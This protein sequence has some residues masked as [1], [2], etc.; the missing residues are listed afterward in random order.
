MTNDDKHKQLA[1]D[2]LKKYDKESNALEHKGLM[3]KFVSALAIAFSV[4]QLYT[5]IFGV[6][7]AQLQRAVHLGFG[8]ALVYLLYPTRRA[9]LEDGV[10]PIDLVLAFLGAAAPAYLIIEYNELVLRAGTVTE[11]DF[12][13]GLLGVLL[14]IEATRRIVGLPMVCVVLIFLGYAFLGPE[15]PGV[16][17][18]RGLTPQQLVGHLFFT[19]EGIFG[20]PLGVSSTFIFLF[21]LF[22]AYL[23]STGLGKFFI[24]LANALAGWAS[25]GPAKVAV[26][27]S[28]LMGTVS[29]SS[30]A[31]VAGTGSF[32]IPMMKKLG[33][34]KEFAGAVE[35]AASTGGQLMPPVMG[36]AAF[37]MAE[38]VG[39]PYIEIVKA[40]IIPAILYFTGVWLGVHFEAKRKGLKGIPKEELPRA[41]DIFRE[42]GHLALPLV[43][44]IY[45]LVS[46]YTP[47]RAAL[48][49]IVLSILASCLR[50]ST[51]MKPIDVI[52]GLEAGAKGVLGVLVACA[53]AGII[54]GVVTKTGVGLKLASALL[55]FAGGLMLP[56]MF[57]TMITALLLGMG[58]PTTANYV[59]TSTIAA[60]ALMQMG[61]PVLAAHMF[62]F[63]FGIIADVTPPVA[64]AAYAGA[65]ISGGNALKT[66][67]NASKLAIAAFIIPYIFVLSPVILMINATPMGLVQTLI[68]AM[69]GMIALSSS[70]IGHLV[71]DMNIVER[72]VLFV[73][74]LLMIIPG[75]ATD[76]GGLA[77]FAIVIFLQKRRQKQ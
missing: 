47:M 41:W 8:L 5:A 39:V 52:N 53:S 73:G 6:L 46:G 77:V 3:A 18:H 21:I 56:T 50:A 64:L 65:A 34:D 71:T 38:F 61:I 66:G 20:I 32:T 74:G 67:V 30:V 12:L 54:I 15:M 9:W 70:L 22:G 40:A 69:I 7:D 13:V 33:Y 62:V 76:L 2:A 37:L 68:T 19:T 49:A 51:R 31:N 44:I 1:D 36:A 60:P 24:D 42:R 14:V 45:L 75:A 28:G 29:G 48:F 23:E 63:Y 35:A 58:V 27:S 11:T 25:G 16:L 72:I 59:I 43:V 10:H 26:L 4:F 55:S 57:F 17:A